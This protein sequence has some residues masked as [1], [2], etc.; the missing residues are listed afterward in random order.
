M[1]TQLGIVCLSVLVFSGLAGPAVALPLAAP[2]APFVSDQQPTTLLLLCGAL[3]V[4]DPTPTP[5][6]PTLEKP[7]LS[8]PRPVYRMLARRVLRWWPQYPSPPPWCCWRWD[9]SA[10]SGWPGGTGNAR[11]F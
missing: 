6:V 1:R 8:L 7:N 3:A 4:F 9:W 2:E 11:I 10:C 5:L